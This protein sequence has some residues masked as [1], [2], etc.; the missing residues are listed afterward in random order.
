MHEVT[1]NLLLSFT[2]FIREKQQPKNTNKQT[3]QT[4]NPNKPKPNRNKNPTK[5]LLG[6]LPFLI[7]IT[8]F[9]KA[10]GGIY[11]FPYHTGSPN[12]KLH[13]KNPVGETAVLRSSL[14]AGVSRSS[15]SSRE[16][17]RYTDETPGLKGT[18]IVV[19]LLPFYWLTK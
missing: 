17:P 6:P 14:A 8:Y 18:S 1:F 12:P 9:R 3:K 7:Y 15:P 4:K 11:L 10:M 16:V 19:T 2:N 13:A 5:L